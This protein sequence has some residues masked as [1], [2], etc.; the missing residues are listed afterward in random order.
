LVAAPSAMIS[1][2]L[3][4]LPLT[5]GFWF[6]Q[7]RS[8]RPSNL[9]STYSSALSIHD[10]LGVDEGDRAVA[11]RAG[12]PCR[13]SSATDL[14]LHAGGHDGGSTLSSGTACRCMFEPISARLASS[15]SRNGIS[16]ADTPTICLGE[17]ST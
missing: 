5:I 3:H 9:R 8:L 2:F 14:L 17:M 1:P 7:V 11:S 15:C 10:A 16:A 13:C 12:R 6:R 4:L